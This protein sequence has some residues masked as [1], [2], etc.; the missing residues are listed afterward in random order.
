MAYP[1]PRPDIKWDPPGL[2]QGVTVRRQIQGEWFAWK[3]PYNGL[4]SQ[5]M[6]ADLLSVSVM[7]VN[8]WVRARKLRHVK[9]AG[10]PSAIP[11][12]EIKKARK[13]LAEERR[14]RGVR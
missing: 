12:S 3:I 6:A 13:A 1:D 9:V 7:S 11:L 4:V 10:M 8:N 5:A 2:F 14:K